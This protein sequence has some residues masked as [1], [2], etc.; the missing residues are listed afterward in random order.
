MELDAASSVP[1]CSSPLAVLLDLGEKLRTT[2]VAQAGLFTLH[3]FPLRASYEIRWFRDAIAEARRWPAIVQT[4]FQKQTCRDA[5]A[6]SCVQSVTRQRLI[7]TALIV[8]HSP[9]L[10]AFLNRVSSRFHKLP[11]VVRPPKNTCCDKYERTQQYAGANHNQYLAG[12]RH[13]RNLSIPRRSQ[14][15]DRALTSS[16]L[17]PWSP[18]NRAQSI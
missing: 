11:T 10:F 2:L 1:F 12:R 9:K 5:A 13:R 8:V 4:S 18:N 16:S 6:D 17:T 14:E 7:Q 3:A 15:S